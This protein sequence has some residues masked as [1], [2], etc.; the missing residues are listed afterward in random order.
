MIELLNLVLELVKYEENIKL[1]NM[2]I[3]LL[4]QLWEQKEVKNEE[5]VVLRIL[6][7]R[8]SQSKVS[9][10]QNIVK[11]IK[12]MSKNI[13]SHCNWL[14][15]LVEYVDFNNYAN[16]SQFKEEILN[17]LFYIL[18]TYKTIFI[19]ESDQIRNLVNALKPYLTENG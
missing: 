2:N 17:L 3:G 12:E 19:Q 14:D 16:N 9:V 18:N 15:L 4:E 13:Q 8:I 7:E 10:R 11:L 1:Q 5:I 6:V